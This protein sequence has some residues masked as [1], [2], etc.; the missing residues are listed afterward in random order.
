MN[1]DIRPVLTDQ[2]EAT[3]IGFLGFNFDDLSEEQALQ[4]IRVLIG[5]RDFSYLITPNVDHVVTFN[6]TSDPVILDAYRRADITLCD[7][8]ILTKLAGL[9]GVKLVAVPGSDLT[10]MLLQVANSDW[11]FAVIGGDAAL[12][13][14]IATIYPKFE[15]I[16]FQPP[17][18][19]R[20]D[21]SARLKIAEFVESA[22]ADIIFFAIGAPQ[23]EITCHEIARRGRATG[24][25]LC[26]GASLEFLAGAKKRAPSWMQHMSL[27]W[28][29][30]LGSEPKRLW[31]R[32]LLDGPPIFSIW[33]RWHRVRA[34][35][36]R[37]ESGSSQSGVR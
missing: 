27:E 7:S 20:N 10:R 36:R 21:P 1:R 34:A 35:R 32:Y 13:S 26:I 2:N 22:S 28:L 37:A 5:K 24:V 16:F 29:Y 14:K 6:Q 3:K 11:R 18:R 9:S 15:W 25:A 33:W 23:S 17:M 31:R 30:R 12:H 19:V 8:R 4:H